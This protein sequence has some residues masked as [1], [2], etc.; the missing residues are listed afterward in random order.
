MLDTL[1]LSIAL[2]AAPVDSVGDRLPPVAGYAFQPRTEAVTT[3]ESRL[4]P[5]AE[6]VA[7]ATRPAVRAARPNIWNVNE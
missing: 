6:A 2:H 1:L 7:L 3:R 4:A 5:L